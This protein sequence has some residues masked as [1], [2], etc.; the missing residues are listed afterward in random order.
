MPQ[1]HKFVYILIIFLSLSLGVVR[2]GKQ[3]QFIRCKK[4]ADC[5]KYMCAP[6]KVK[7][8]IDLYCKCIALGLDRAGTHCFSL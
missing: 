6:M 2:A 1:N 8:N 4:N 7:C 5:P 3:H